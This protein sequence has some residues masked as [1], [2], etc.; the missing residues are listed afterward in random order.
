MTGYL[1]P[2][3]IISYTIFLIMKTQYILLAAAMVTLAVS[4]PFRDQI[5][6]VNSLE[7]GRN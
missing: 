7:V 1:C 6:L 5:A 4:I 2:I 3:F